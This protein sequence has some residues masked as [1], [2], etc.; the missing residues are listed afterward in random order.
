MEQSKHTNFELSQKELQEVTGGDSKTDAT[1]GVTGLGAG[2][3]IGLGAHHVG[4]QIRDVGQQ[5]RDV[6]QQIRGI[7]T[8]M[9]VMSAVG[10]ATLAHTRTLT[11]SAEILLHR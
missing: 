5:I 4:K 7:G 11:T 8:H 2:V 6:G 1:I 3:A 9:A 10:E